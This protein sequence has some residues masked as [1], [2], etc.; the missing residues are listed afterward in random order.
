MQHT[1]ISSKHKKKRKIKTI[2]IYLLYYPWDVIIHDEN[3]KGNWPLNIY[4]LFRNN[5][6]CMCHK[7]FCGHLS[8]QQCPVVQQF[9]TGITTAPHR[10]THSHKEAVKYSSISPIFIVRFSGYMPSYW[11]IG[12]LRGWKNEFEMTKPPTHSQSPSSWLY[13]R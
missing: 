9:C 4:E 11:E 13:Y 8:I 1:T 6:I 10:I 5:V 3:S 7:P 2:R 12:V